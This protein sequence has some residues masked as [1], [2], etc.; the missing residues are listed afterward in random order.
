M[1]NGEKLKK[2][3]SRKILVKKRKAKVLET[4]I[5]TMH[6][7]Y[8]A[9]SLL[10]SLSESTSYILPETDGIIGS[11]T[12]VSSFCSSSSLLSITIVYYLL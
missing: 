3:W 4:I 9:M 1:K 8:A 6:A 11:Y 10:L 7:L 12:V 5:P 2:M